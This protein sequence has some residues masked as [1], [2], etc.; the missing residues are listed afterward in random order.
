MKTPGMHTYKNNKLTEASL[1]S[2]IKNSNKAMAEVTGIL[3]GNQGH[4]AFDY[5]GFFQFEDLP[6]RNALKRDFLERSSKDEIWIEHTIGT[7]IFVGIDIEKWDR[8]KLPKIIQ[9]SGKISPGKVSFIFKGKNIE[10]FT[11]INHSAGNSYVFVLGSQMVKGCTFGGE[12]A[13]SSVLDEDRLHDWKINVYK[14]PSTLNF[15]VTPLLQAFFEVKGL[16]GSDI[17]IFKHPKTGKSVFDILYNNGNKFDLSIRNMKHFVTIPII[18]PPGLKVLDIK[19]NNEKNRDEY[20][21]LM[22]TRPGLSFF[23]RFDFHFATQIPK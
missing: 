13:I 5:G 2:N 7:S 11:I 9:I 3:D 22:S 17:S 16:S 19:R 14:N 23:K 4:L 10:D 18:Y 8:L 12:I 20:L 6:E 1:A 21:G 15:E